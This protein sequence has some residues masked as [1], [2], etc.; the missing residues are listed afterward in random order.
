MI[1]SK[2]SGARF[3]P[4]APQAARDVAC[5]HLEAGQAQPH[6]HEDWQFAV[7]DIPAEVCVAGR[8]RYTVGPSDITVVAP[9]EMHSECG[10]GRHAPHWRMLL[11]PPSILSIAC[12]GLPANQKCE[13]RRFTSEVLPDPA[14]ALA[15]RR[16]LLDSEDGLVDGVEFV[17]R[18]LPWLDDLLDR[19]RG[20]GGRPPRSR[21]VERAHAYI[22]RRATRSVT[23]AEVAIAAGVAV[24]HLVRSFS[25][26][27]GLPPMSYQT[28]VRVARSKRLL[29]Q[30]VSAS[31]VAYECG[32]ADQSHLI[33]HFKKC[34]GLTPGAFQKQYCDQQ[35]VARG[36]TDS[37]VPEVESNA[38]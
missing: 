37:G 19:H 35:P 6:V 27:V 14:G 7:A 2:K 18:A 1:G 34:Y 36:T 8:W 25:A 9:Y 32:F 29:A 30:G 17:T 23:L 15:L 28:Q 21:A 16:L 5:A 11:V 3:W 38:A 31:S 13:H 12:Q 26:A 33:R 10:A 20:D 4:P 24:G 22:R